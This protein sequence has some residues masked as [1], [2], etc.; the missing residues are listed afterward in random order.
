MSIPVQVAVTSGT[1]LPA[2]EEVQARLGTIG[3]AQMLWVLSDLE[4]PDVPQRAAAQVRAMLGARRHEGGFAQIVLAHDVAGMNHALQVLRGA[5]PGRTPWALVVIGLFEEGDVVEPL[6]AGVSSVHVVPAALAY[7]ELGWRERE[8]SAANLLGLLTDLARSDRARESWQQWVATY[9]GV[10]VTLA[11][12]AR[13][14]APM[15]QRVLARRLASRVVER[16]IDALGQGQRPQTAPRL[17]DPP[18]APDHDVQEALSQR[19]HELGEKV[20]VRIVGADDD[21]QPLPAEE[22]LHQRARREVRELPQKLED[23]LKRHGSDLRDKALAWQGE[24]RQW[25]DAALEQASFAALPGVIARLEAW[26]ERLAL[27]MHDGSQHGPRQALRL[28]PPDSAQLRAAVQ[29]LE[30]ELA[31]HDDSHL[32]F[33]GWSLAIGT[34][35]GLATAAG[36]QALGTHAPLAAGGVGT[37]VVG[38]GAGISAVRSRLAQ[39]QLRRLLAQEQLARQAYRAAWTK[40]I[41]RQIADIGAVLNERMVRFASEVVQ[42]E[43][44]WLRSVRD[45]LSDLYQQYQKP[46]RLR[47]G[48]DSAFESD[49]RL[50]EEFYAKAEQVA[51]A[52]P[53]FAEYEGQLAQSNWRQRL[54]FMNSDALLKQCE[55]AYGS[56]REQIPFDQRAELRD[57]A[58]GP[59]GVAIRQML[60][61]LADYLPPEFGADTMV[62]LPSRLS[63]AVPDDRVGAL[64]MHL[65]VSDV[66]VAVSRPAAPRS[67]WAGQ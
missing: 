8:R 51:D 15:V 20:A 59:T 22:V 29:A 16:M 12:A 65:G 33:G 25:V 9:A 43:L 24:L 31:A 50:P 30:A 32:L 54:G 1:L 18:A 55:L 66:F 46:E 52:S 10:R 40:L 17:A 58:L 14:Q 63:D 47:M 44:V 57:V 64:Q 27:P 2:V 62:V 35:V 19:A 28:D 23:V 5:E 11:Q 48:S 37:A 45:T 61:R 26:L 67:D 56:F 4:Q 42:G 21:V 3:G 38:A 13:F 49:I 60:D 53:L 34:T 7:R 6:P 41:E 36:L 39:A